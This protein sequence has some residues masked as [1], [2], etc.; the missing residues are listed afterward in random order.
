[1][2]PFPHQ[3]R[4]SIAGAPTGNV[5]LS[6]P[7]LT[8]L[9][10]APPAEFGG[11]GDQWSPETL[12]TAALADCF[13]LSFRAVAAA[14]KFEWRQ[15]ECDVEGT[16]DRIERVSLFTRFVIKAKLTV[17]GGADTERGKKLLEKAEQV[18]LISASLKAER[19]LQA[20]VVTG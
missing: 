3:Y 1:M 10:S 7:G 11:P 9:A 12:L 6:S 13:V 2:H 16:L 20:E 17:P 18:C 4:V 15:L 14:S 19:H 8:S 5:T